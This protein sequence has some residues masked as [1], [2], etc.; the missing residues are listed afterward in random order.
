[1][2]DQTLKPYG[3]WPSPVQPAVLAQNIRLADVMWS[4]TEG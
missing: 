3:L 4:R 1:M 2:S